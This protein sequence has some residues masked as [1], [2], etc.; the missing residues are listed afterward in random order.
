MAKNKIRIVDGVNLNVIY[1]DKF[2]TNLLSIN[3]MTPLNRKTAAMNALLPMV[4]RRGSGKYPNMAKINE[5]MEFLYASSMGNNNYK[6]GEI[7]MR[8]INSWMLENSFVPDDT[9]V[10]G[11]TF[12]LIADVLFNPLTDA[13]TG[14]FLKSFVDGEKKSLIDSINAKINNKDQYAIMKCQQLMCKNEAYGIEETGSVED[15]QRITP[16]SLYEHYKWFLQSARIEVFLV[17]RG[18]PEL[19]AGKLKEKFAEI[20]RNPVDEIKT[21]VIRKASGNVQNVVEDQPVNQG[22]LCL[23]F[24]TSKILSDDDFVN[25]AMMNEIYGGSPSSKLFMNVRE[26]LSLCYYCQSV[27]DAFKGTMIVRSGIEVDKKDIAQN[28]ILLQLEN[29]K[30]G[31]I[32]DEEMSAARNSLRNGY[33]QISDSPSSLESWYLGRMLAGLDESPED[34]IAKLDNVT[35]EQVSEAAAGITLD[36]I[37]FLNGTLRGTLGSAQQDDTDTEDGDDE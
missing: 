37:Y 31:I 3:F 12:D 32:T 10:F 21:E 30:N 2:K 4:L 1:T 36:T 6:R 28:E 24:R 11:D 9:D 26:K 22:K 16:E 7:H 8:S 14:V 29:I 19:L 27:P 33:M 18:N 5:R 34:F 20:D 23:G 13:E 17:G 35:K 25:F 15:V